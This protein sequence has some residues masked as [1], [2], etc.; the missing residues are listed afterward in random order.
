MGLSNTAVPKYYKQFRDQVISGKI[1]VCENIS[2][3][4]N[5]IDELIENPMY[6][7]DEDAVEGWIRFCETELTLTNGD[8]LYLLDSFKLWGEEVYGWYYFVKRQV[9]DIKTSS[10]KTK[11]VKKRLTQKQYL[12]VPRGNAKTMYE[13]THQGYGLIIDPST[14]HNI[15]TAPTLKQAEEVLSPLRTAI[16]RARGPLFKFLTMG[17][18]QNTSGS[19][20][21]RKKLSST[22]KGIENFLTNSVLETRPMAI[23]KLQGL[24]TKYNTIDEWLSCDIREDVMTP[25]EQGAAKIDNW[26]II[27]VSSEG[28]VRNGPGDSIKMELSKILNGEYY[29]PHTSIWWYCLDD[30]K[31]VG[32]PALWQK[33]IPNIDKTVSYETI[34]REVE[35]AE[36]SPSTRN[37]ILAKRFNIATEGYSYFFRYEETLCTSRRTF[38]S[39]PCS[40]GADLSRGDDFCAFTFLFPL[41]NGFYGVKCLSFI[42]ARTYDNLIPA[43]RDKYASFIKEGSLI[44]MEG[45]ILNMNEVFDL[46]DN[47][48]IEN[49]YDVRAL[50]YDPYNADQF[51]QLW[52]VNHGPYGICKVIQGS[53]TESVPLG[54]IKI[55][56]ED[57]SLLFDQEIM[58]Y[59]M[60]NCIVLEDNNGNRKLLK[61]RRDKKI[62][63][64]SALMDAYV[65]EKENLDFFV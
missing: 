8:P 39:M 1:P 12:I 52:A 42:T 56:A 49:D 24:Q 27:S 28:T 31:E 35:R 30:V 37:D 46:L 10:W 2:K 64:V 14:T 19:N 23:A 48:I 38:N 16:A 50:G 17:S 34:Q 5:R 36:N 25:L 59:C 65:A 41:S 20:R 18:M 11:M 4:M 3:E 62:D 44:I 15:T 26:L 22:K 47:H 53:K 9:Y 7:Y 63:N 55:L 21:D 51:I 45:N 6:Y 32:N 54:E 60:G 29:A 43:M 40:L 33:A 58:K 61:E 13:A 57:R